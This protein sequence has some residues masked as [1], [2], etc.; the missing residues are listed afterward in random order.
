LET[1]RGKDTLLIQGNAG[2]VTRAALEALPSPFWAGLDALSDTLKQLFPDWRLGAPS[3]TSEMAE[4]AWSPQD[5]LLNWRAFWPKQYKERQA[6]N[7]TAPCQ[8]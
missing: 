6:A 7:K 1:Y 3:E 5:N 2:A 4:D 8:L